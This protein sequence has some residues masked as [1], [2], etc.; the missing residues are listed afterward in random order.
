RALLENLE[1]R[2]LLAV[3]PPPAVATD[4]LTGQPIRV[5]VSNP[6]NAPFGFNESNPSISASPNDPNKMVMVWQE[7]AQIPDDSTPINV[8]GAF[9]RDG[10]QTWT[11]LTLPLPVFD[12]SLSPDDTTTR[13]T[14]VTDP[15]VAFDRNDSFYIVDAQQFTQNTQGAIV[16]QKFDF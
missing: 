7:G 10:G 12:P 15:T 11:A 1:P 16:M 13:L 2:T 8:R 6:S 5:D 3:L 4:P 14:R 9:S